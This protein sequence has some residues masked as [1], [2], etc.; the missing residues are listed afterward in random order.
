MA[1]RFFHLKADRRREVRQLL[2]SFLVA[3]LS[4]FLCVMSAPAQVDK[5]VQRVARVKRDVNKIGV[6]ENV[7]VKLLDGTQLRGRVDEIGDDYFVLIEKKTADTR[8]LTFAQVKQ[9]GRVVDNPF[10]DPKVLMGV[11]FI[12]IIIGLCFW[13]KGAD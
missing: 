9:I 4:N 10:S 3:V 13:A 1:E 8:K 2:A 5:D 11:A 7:N 12:P 6:D